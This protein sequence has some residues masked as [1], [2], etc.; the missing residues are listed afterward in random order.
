[1]N[2]QRSI[3]ILVIE[4]DGQIRQEI[5]SY[6]QQIGYGVIQADNATESLEMYRQEC[7]D[8]VLTDLDLPGIDGMKVLSVIL[9]DSS[10]TPV[11]IVSGVESLGNAIKALKRGAWDHV[12]KPIT[13][14]GLL[15]YAVDRALERARLVKENKNYQSF[16]ES[17]VQKKTAELHQAQK[18]EAVG[19]LAGGIAHDFNNIL[20]AIIGFTELARYKSEEGSEVSEYLHQVLRASYRAKDLVRQI[21]TFS[22]KTNT[23]RH[24]IQASLVI[25]EAIK[26]LR[27]TLPMTTQLNQ[28]FSDGRGM[29]MADPTELHQV[30]TN[31]CTN[32]F[33]ALPEEQGCISVRMKEVSITDYE[34]KK[35][36]ELTE[37]EYLQITVSD[38]GCGMDSKVLANIFDPFFTTKEKEQGTGLG[39]S[40]VHGIVTACGGSIVAQSEPEQGTTFTLHFPIVEGMTS[41][42]VETVKALPTGNEKILFVDDEKDLRLLAERM[43]VYLGYSVVCCASGQD[44]LETFNENPAEFDLIITDQSM[45]HMPGTELS[46]RILAVDPAIPIFL[47][48]GYSSIIN[49]EKALAEGFCGFLLKP[50][51]IEV[52]ARKIREK[53]DR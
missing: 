14:M 8:L 34:I 38:D 5:T 46:R 10:D 19:I 36:P 6:L 23:E 15:K 48:T 39:L 42:T 9:K 12:T 24:P 25:K 11:I 4:N 31:L 7:P 33:H 30:I 13:D 1:M 53:L 41:D 35:C 2:M 49:E 40:V 32:A 3:T 21:L 17:E 18:L 51:S 27:A 50:L 26:L 20:G 28:E 37:G 43:L 47:C 45:P 16:L 52:L 44:A 29:I 22:R